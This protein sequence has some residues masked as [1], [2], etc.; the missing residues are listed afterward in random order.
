MAVIMV[1]MKVRMLVA[2]LVALKGELTVVRMVAQKVVD[3]VA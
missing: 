3:L 1:E 2:L